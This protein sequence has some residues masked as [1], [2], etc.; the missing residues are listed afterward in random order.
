MKN[1]PRRRVVI[2]VKQKRKKLDFLKTQRLGKKNP[3]KG[4]FSFCTG[5]KTPSLCPNNMAILGQCQ[6][7]P[8]IRIGQY[9]LLLA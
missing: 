6:V 2:E 1:P 9:G 8:K 5:V 4:R 3:P 7:R